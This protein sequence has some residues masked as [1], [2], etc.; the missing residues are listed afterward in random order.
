M[1]K[2]NTLLLLLKLLFF[3]CSLFLCKVSVQAQDVILIG[4]QTGANDQISFVATTNISA[5]TDIYFRD[6]EW[7]GTGFVD[8]NEGTLKYT[9]PASGLSIGTVVQISASPLSASDGG[10]VV[11]ADNT[12]DLS[13]NG[14]MVYAFY[15]TGFNAPTEILSLLSVGINTEPTTAEDPTGDPLAPDVLVIY[16]PGT[17]DNAQYNG[18]RVN[19]SLTDL[20]NPVN[21]VSISSPITLNTALFTFPCATLSNFTTNA[22]TTCAGTAVQACVTVNASNNLATNVIFSDGTNKIFGVASL[23]PPKPKLHIVKLN[24]LAPYTMPTATIYAGDVI[25]LPGTSGHPISTTLIPLGANSVMG[26]TSNVYYSLT[27]VG[28][29]GIICDFHSTMTGSF[30]VLTRPNTTTQICADI[31]PTNTN[32][33]AASV[34]LTASIAGCLNTLSKTIMVYPELAISATSAG[35]CTAINATVSP[36]SCSDVTYSVTYTTGAGV[37]SGTGTSFLPAAGT[38]GNVVFTLT[39]SGAPIACSTVSSDP[40]TFNCVV[41]C[42]VSIGT[43]SLG[44]CSFGTPSTAPLSVPITWLSAP[45][46]ESIIVTVVGANPSTQTI[47][48]LATS[49]NQTL[50]FTVPT[51]GSTNNAVTAK[52]STTTSCSDTDFYNA[53]ASGATVSILGTTVACNNSVYTYSAS[54]N[55]AANYVWTVSGNGV[56]Q[57]G[58]GTNT[59]SVLWLNGVAGTVT[60]FIQQ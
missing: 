23:N 6:D 60:V 58:A 25:L 44:N 48:P 53:T 10:T 54:P 50:T 27:V 57:S 2:H 12:F 37:T 36:A 26:A 46:G 35:A 38:A 14:D 4:F 39:N 24:S 9:V 11:S 19:T 29:Y 13:T 43:L 1:Q 32:C 28:G 33:G 7:N 40:V 20:I 34:N 5:G 59:I 45:S 3:C 31:I 16:I 22:N 49:G 15:G 52:F 55:N 17:N 8:A 41:P 42:S 47:V 51:N 18:T 30:N 21:W 56:I